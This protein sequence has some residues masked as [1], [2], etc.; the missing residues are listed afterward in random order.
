MPPSPPQKGPAL[1]VL[2]RRNRSRSA[3]RTQWLRCVRGPVRQGA[4]RLA[5]HP[6][7]RRGGNR[8][9]WSTSTRSRPTPTPCA[10]GRPTPPG[11][12]PLQCAE[13]NNR[14]KRFKKAAFRFTNLRHHRVRV[15]LYGEPHWK[16]LP[17]IRLYANGRADRTS[18][19]CARR[20]SADEGDGRAG[21]STPERSISRSVPGDSPR[22]TAHYG[23][24]KLRR[25][26]TKIGRLV[27]EQIRVDRQLPLDQGHGSARVAGRPKATAPTTTP[28]RRKNAD[29]PT[30]QALPST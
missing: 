15:V 20:V 25:Q 29:A 5:R 17:L 30:C 19:W 2:E 21:C 3:S 22:Q 18:C 23:L 1:G 13:A 16:L 24:G 10:P 9:G 26:P 6:A 28:S 8:S 14:L 27:G 4:R 12:P 11:G 7:A